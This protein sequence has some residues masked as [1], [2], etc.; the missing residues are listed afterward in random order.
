MLDVS[1]KQLLQFFAFHGVYLESFRIIGPFRIEYTGLPRKQVTCY[2]RS[3]NLDYVTLL[4]Y[5]A[6]NDIKKKPLSSIS[7]I[8]YTDISI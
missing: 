4:H 5:N 2:G 8:M 7:Y 1:L 3:H 6:E